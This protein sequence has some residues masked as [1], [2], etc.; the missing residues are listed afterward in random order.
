MISRGSLISSSFLINT[1][2]RRILALLLNFWDLKSH[3]LLMV[4]TSLRPS[5]FMIFS[6]MLVSLIARLPLLLLSLIFNSSGLLT[7][8]HFVMLFF[9]VSLLAALFILL[10]LV[11]ISLMLFKW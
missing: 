3:L 11:Q 4:T 1:L 2:R 10:S 5:M 6:L 8:H 7:V 9:I